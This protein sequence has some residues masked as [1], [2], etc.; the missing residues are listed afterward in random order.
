[1]SAAALEAEILALVQSYVEEQV[2]PDEPLAKQGLDSLAAM[3]LRQK[4]QVCFAGAACV[5]CQ[6]KPTSCCL[7]NGTLAAPCAA[8]AVL[9]TG[10]AAARVTGALKELKSTLSH[11]FTVQGW[12]L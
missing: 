12:Q 8:S 3:E 9:L 1:M 5:L 10:C 4:L 11:V 6:S 2:A 7:C